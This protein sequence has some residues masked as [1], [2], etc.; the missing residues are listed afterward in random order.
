MNIELTILLLLL[1]IAFVIIIIS[2]F[3]K[4]I[5]DNYS[6][7]GTSCPKGCVRG[8]CN[9]SSSDEDKDSCKYDF[10]CD[11]CKDNKTDQFYIDLNN[12]REII[13]LYYTS[14]NMDKDDIY[15]LNDMINKNNK[16]IQALDEKIKIM[17]S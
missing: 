11:Y 8:V 2:I 16:Y 17:N 6:F 5:C 9:K 12:N 1:V 7:H 13:P 14:K 15:K 10:Q 4:I 3:A